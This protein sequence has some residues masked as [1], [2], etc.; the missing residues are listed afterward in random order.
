MQSFVATADGANLLA[1]YKRA[2]NILRKEGYAASV[3]PAQTGVSGDDALQEPREAP[4][5]A[6]ATDAV[7]SYAP[8]PAE[9]ALHA[10]LDA[11]EPAAAAAV[12]AEEFE[13]AM[14]ALAT[15]RA[16]IDAFFDGVTVNDPDPDKRAA[17]LALLARVRAAVHAVADFSRIEG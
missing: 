4:A 13:R 16:P 1:G 17:R 3:T 2:A 5:F 10:A 7:L 15:L 6:G 11:A 9:A 12:E 8:E 14:A